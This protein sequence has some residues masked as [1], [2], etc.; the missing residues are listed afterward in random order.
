LVDNEVTTISQLATGKGGTPTSGSGLCIGTATTQVNCYAYVDAPTKIYCDLVYNYTGD[1]TTDG[2]T[3]QTSD[4]SNPCPSGQSYGTVNGIGRC[5]ASG[6]PTPPAPTSSTTTTNKVDNGDGTST[7]T[8]TTT[9]GTSTT[10]TTTTTNNTTGAPISS[11]TTTTGSGAGTTGAGATDQAQYCRDNPEAPACKSAS[12]SGSCAAAF[13]C[14][15]DAVQCAIAREIHVRACTF[16]DTQTTLSERGNELASGTDPDATDHPAHASQKT[17]VDVGGIVGSRPR[18]LTQGCPEDYEF[19]F[20]G[21]TVTVPFS[22]LCTPMQAVGVIMVALAML[23]AG[24]IVL[25]TG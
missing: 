12:F 8:T 9:T 2:T 21:S 24:R 18:L 13:Q 5:L 6:G 11:T 23:G 14:E 17:E 3:N 20:K 4:T 15:G 19:T 22:M 7:T 25:A 16:Y 10:T 1:S